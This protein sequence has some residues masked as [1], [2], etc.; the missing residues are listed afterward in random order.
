MAENND[1]I[2]D[3]NK[4]ITQRLDKLKVLRL[5]V[6]PTLIIFVALTKRLNYKLS[7]LNLIKKRLLS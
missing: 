5:N 3:I 7:L 1:Q 6:T 4:L 2:Q